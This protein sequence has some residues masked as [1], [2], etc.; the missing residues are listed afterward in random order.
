M[1]TK[2]ELDTWQDWQQIAGFYKDA[3]FAV[4]SIID[5]PSDILG[6]SMRR[7]AQIFVLSELRTYGGRLLEISSRKFPAKKKE[8]ER[9]FIMGEILRQI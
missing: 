6:E 7:R 9:M 1:E 3:V 2:N 5:Y 4:S 8:L